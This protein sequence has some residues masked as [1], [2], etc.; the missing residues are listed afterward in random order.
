MWFPPKARLAWPIKRP[1]QNTQLP[2]TNCCGRKSPLAGKFSALCGFGIEPWCRSYSSYNS[3]A[4]ES[5]HGKRD[6]GVPGGVPGN[7][8]AIQNMLLAARAFGLGA[9]V[10]TLHVNFEREAEPRSACRPASTRMPFCRS[11]TRW[12]GSGRFAAWLWPMSSLRTVGVRFSGC[13]A[14]PKHPASLPKP[15]PEHLPASVILV[16]RTGRRFGHHRHTPF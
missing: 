4:T 7:D 12:D 13:V 2:A 5:R 16:C 10:T 15:L 11:G 9:T 1:S 3:P 14:D 6:P 8:P